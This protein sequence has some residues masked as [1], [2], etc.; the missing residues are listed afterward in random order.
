MAHRKAFGIREMDLLEKE[1]RIG[2]WEIRF[3]R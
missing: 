3:S 2:W 1:A